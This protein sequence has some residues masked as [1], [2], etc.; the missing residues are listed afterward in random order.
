MSEGT[1]Q[2][3]TRQRLNMMRKRRRDRVWRGRKEKTG[4]IGEWRI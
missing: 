2:K 4:K 3:R 1:E